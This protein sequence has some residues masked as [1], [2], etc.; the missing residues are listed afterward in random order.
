VRAK[1]VQNVIETLLQMRVLPVV[2]E[3]DT[4]STEEIEAISTFGDND[5]LSAIV[6]ELAHTD[7]L[8]IFS[9]IDGLYSADPHKNPDA[10]LIS[11][12]NEIT[13]HLFEIAGG[14]GSA[15][16]TGGMTTKLHAAEIALRAGYSMAILNGSNPEL[17]YDLLEDKQVGTMFCC[18]KTE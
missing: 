13:P 5:T 12:V 7:L 3:N 17:L 8:V 9:D 2:N 18:A 11:Q 16:G 1:N 14:A 15:R 6:G 4:V 10:K